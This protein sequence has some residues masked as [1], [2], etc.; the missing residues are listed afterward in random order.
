[1][2]SC[3][4]LD[5]GSIPMQPIGHVRGGRTD[6]TDDF[7]GGAT[8]RI[9]LARGIDPSSLDGIEEFS[10]VEVFFVFDK[11]DP[12]RAVA[13]T[14][15]PRNNPEWPLVGVFAQRGKN[16]PNRLGA[17]IVRVL[18]REGSE[19]V[20]SELDAVDGTPVLDIKPVM[21]EFLPRGDVSQPEWSHEIMSSYWERPH[22]EGT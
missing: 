18:A 7:W 21:R 16:R 14:R 22:G 17:T 9:E 15:R 4:E 10:H 19:L 11:V 5:A 20:V 2:T 8:S 12:S 13:G 6:P 3:T 1:M